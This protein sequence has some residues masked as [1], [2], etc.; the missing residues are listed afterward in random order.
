M[1]FDVE[2]FVADLGGPRAASNK[3]QVSRTTPYRWLKTGRVGS[4]VLARI[5]A[6]DPQ[7]RVDTYFKEGGDA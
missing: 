3:A 1:R 5:K 7:F 6:L 4:Q 2:K